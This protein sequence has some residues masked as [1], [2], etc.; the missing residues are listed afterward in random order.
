MKQEIFEGTAIELTGYYKDTRDY[1]S[2]RPQ[3]TGADGTFYGVY[4][5]RD[6]SKSLGF[7][8]AF[9]QYVSNRFNFGLDYTFSSVEGSNSDPN[10]E[11]F[12]IAGRDS[13]IDST[14]QLNSTT[15]LVQPL[16]WDRTHIVNG[17]MFY[18]G[19]KWGAN[20]VA[21]FNSGT[22]FTPQ[23]DIPGVTIGEGASVRDL[24]NTSRLPARLTLDF[25]T[26]KSFS[27]SN[28]SSL[29]L[30]L[31]IFNLLDSKIV[32]ALYGDSGEASSPLPIN[33]V[34]S[35]DP[36]YYANP[37]FYGEPRR[38]QLGLSISF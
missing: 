10:S 14:D 19:N 7:T 34:D 21:R 1:V 30:Y 13:Q 37:G 16:D 23:R 4:F 38:I 26:Y 11:F 9:N 5:N 6:F 22:P 29:E 24:R 20:L 27:F 36:G 2:S 32:N 12:D 25:N 35:A 31:N 33:T 18:S 15:K 8:F 28:G 17:S 3:I